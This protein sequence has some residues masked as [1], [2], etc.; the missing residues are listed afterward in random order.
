M[1][2]NQLGSKNSTEPSFHPFLLPAALWPHIFRSIRQIGM[3]WKQRVCRPELHEPIYNWGFV[4]RNNDPTAR[5]RHLPRPGSISLLRLPPLQPNTRQEQ[6]N[7]PWQWPLSCL[8]HYSN[9]HCGIHQSSR[10][11]RGCLLVWNSQK[12]TVSKLIK[13][14]SR[15]DGDLVIVEINYKYLIHAG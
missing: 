7:N 11:W 10:W 5:L 1:L 12:S 4:H 3:V 9:M 13:M 6:E 14:R 2:T 8:T 15:R